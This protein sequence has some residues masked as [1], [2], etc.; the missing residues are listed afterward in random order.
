MRKFYVLAL[1]LLAVFAVGAVAASGAFA[2][3]TAIWLVSGLL[4]AEKVPVD[5]EGLLTIDVLSSLLG[6]LFEVHC[7]GSFDGTV[8]P[9]AEDEIILV[10]DSL[11]NDIGALGA[12]GT[13]LDCEVVSAPVFCGNTLK[14]AELWPDN[15][16]WA[17]LLELLNNAFVVLV[18]LVNGNIKEPGFDF[19]CENSGGS[20]TEGLCEGPLVADI[21]NLTEDVQAVFLEQSQSCTESGVTADVT[22]EGLI[23]TESGLTLAVSV[24]L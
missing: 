7:I 23:L 11:G 4:T 10:L 19:E 3:E 14:L 21:E 24:S 8:G 9:D 13:G 22:G 18:G 16:P 1:A 17:T 20:F 5:I 12:L 15:L 2:E 6:L